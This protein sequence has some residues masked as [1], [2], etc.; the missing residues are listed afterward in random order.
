[1]LTAKIDLLMKKVENPGL[2]HLKMVVA[3]VTCEECGEICHMG[4]NCP[5]VPLDVNFICNSN[6]GFRPNQGFIAGWSKPSFPFDNSQQGGNG[7]NFNRNEPSLRDII[8]DQVR[9]NDEVGK[10]I[11]ATDKLLENIN[12]K[13]DNFTV[14]TQNQQ[15]FN[16]MLEIQIQLISAAIPSQSNGAS[17]ETSIQESV[18][19]I[20]TIFKEKALKST[21]GSLRGI[22]RDKKPNVDK[23]FST[24]SSRHDK[25]ATPAATSSPVAPTT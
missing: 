22:G 9:I 21:E 4:I 10:K 2:D 25:N 19:S 1:M 14:A 23:N 11:H 8:R 6:N 15:S 18:R 16:K 3:Q 5:M 7:Q 13:M 12:A 24:K 20:L 17:S